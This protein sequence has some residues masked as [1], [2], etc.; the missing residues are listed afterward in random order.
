YSHGLVR[1]R[2][3]RRTRPRNSKRIIVPATPDTTRFRGNR[4]S[5][6]LWTSASTP[7]KSTN[8]RARKPVED[9]MTNRTN[10]SLRSFLRSASTLPGRSSERLTS[11]PTP[12]P[13]AWPLSAYARGDGRTLSVLAPL[14]PRFA[15]YYCLGS[16]RKNRG[17]A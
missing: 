2:R 11:C 7:E 16:E 1:G 10:R 8:G 13:S 3:F 12:V 15:D 5:P 4:Q 6:L 9:T 14:T 17:T